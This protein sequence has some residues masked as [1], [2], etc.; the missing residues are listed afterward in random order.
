[1]P[2]GQTIEPR[3]KG[4]LVSTC[5]YVS[6]CFR[7]KRTG[8]HDSSFSFRSADSKYE[9]GGLPGNLSNRDSPGHVRTF[10][11]QFVALLA[12]EIEVHFLIPVG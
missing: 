1:M 6:L 8:G 4:R 3:G 10:H 12:I 5:N 11:S 9:K 2:L 7:L